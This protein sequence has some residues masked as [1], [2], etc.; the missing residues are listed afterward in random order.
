MPKK[1]FS[2]GRYLINCIGA[3]HLAFRTLENVESISI[4]DS[5]NTPYP[6]FFYIAFDEAFELDS[7]VEIERLRLGHS[8]GFEF[9]ALYPS[10]SEDVAGT[11]GDG[12]TKL[13][14][15]FE[16]LTSIRDHVSRIPS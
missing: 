1:R 6:P 5:T 11:I 12:N 15:L 8:E 2:S 10:R 9:K 13:D 7:N 16:R 14:Q 4:Y 3:S